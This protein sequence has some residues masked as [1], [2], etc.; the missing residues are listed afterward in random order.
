[1]IKSARKPAIFCLQNA[2][3]MLLAMDTGFHDNDPFTVT[4]N[5]TKL[6]SQDG[7]SERIGI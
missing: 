1:L 7:W 6:V 4:T 2:D 5:M 3:W